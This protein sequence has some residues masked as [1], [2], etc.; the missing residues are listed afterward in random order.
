MGRKSRLARVGP[1]HEWSRGYSA[2]ALTQAGVHPIQ[3][4]LNVG[5]AR[6]SPWHRRRYQLL[7]FPVLTPATAAEVM[8]Q[9]RT[10][11][12]LA[13]DFDPEARRW[14]APRTDVMV[15]VTTR[16]PVTGVATTRLVPATVDPDSHGGS[17]K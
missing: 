3:L 5:L 7:G 1:G 2:K 4:L 14:A 11:E 16:D 9:A 6:R 17:L 10:I 12:R 13:P 15:T 8:A